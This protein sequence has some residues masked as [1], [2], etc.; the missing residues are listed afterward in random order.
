MRASSR[1]A[2][3]PIPGVDSQLLSAPEHPQ[4]AAPPTCLAASLRRRCLTVVCRA[5]RA[6]SFE[7]AHHLGVYHHLLF[8]LRMPLS[9]LLA[10][11]GRAEDRERVACGLARWA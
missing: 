7:P 6:M 11:G 9:E 5:Q 8:E 4:G 3:K 10:S 1:G 2:L